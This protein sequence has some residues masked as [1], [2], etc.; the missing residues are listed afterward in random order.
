MLGIGCA[1]LSLTSLVATSKFVAQERPT[2]RDMPSYFG[3]AA[4]GLSNAVPWSSR[5][6]LGHGG[7][8]VRGALGAPKKR[9]M[10]E[11]PTILLTTK[12]RFLEPTMLMKTNQIRLVTHDVIDNKMVGHKGLA[13]A[14]STNTARAG[15]VLSCRGLR[16]RRETTCNRSLRLL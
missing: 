9:E 2:P 8:S 7:R 15:D 10:K 16:N 14:E 6:S 4:R 13:L 3:L 11:E 5:P 1:M 12:D